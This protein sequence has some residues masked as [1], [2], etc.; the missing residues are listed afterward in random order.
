[1]GASKLQ[2]AEEHIYNLGTER[3]FENKIKEIQTVKRMTDK[4]DYIKSVNK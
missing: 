3:D 1:M 2:H 4:F